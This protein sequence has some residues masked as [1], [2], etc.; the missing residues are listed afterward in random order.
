MAV[1]QL[2]RDHPGRLLGVEERLGDRLDGHRRGALAHADEDGAVADH[3]DVAALDGGRLVVAVLVAVV[4]GEVGGGEERVEPVDGPRVQRLSLAG[5]LG[6][7]VDGHAAVDPARVV[8]LEQVVG[9]RGEDEVV[10]L[11]H[12]PLEAVG[13]ERVQ[14]GLEDPTD[15]VLR[16]RLPVEILEEAADR[17][18]E[19][20][21]E[22][23]GGA[24]PVE[25]ELASGRQFE[26]LGQQLAVVVDPHPLVPQGLGE[27]IVL[28]L[29]LGRP[30]HVVEEQLADVVGGQPG[31]LEPGSV[32]D[33]LVEL[34]DLGVDVE[35][36][37]LVSS[38][39]RRRPVRAR[40]GRLGQL[41]LLRPNLGYLRGEIRRLA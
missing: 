5:G 39:L 37:G 26:G 38:G 28:L 34:A 18:D 24:D 1:G 30:H 40:S 12:V 23:L 10:G 21:A 29:G 7:R 36:H 15:E 9:Q 20:R 13:P 2:D 17:I 41:D 16:Q 31:Q 25:D 19:G 35:R 27:G 14:V 11:Q 8:P 33:G 32:E 3:M 4:G 6:H 22:D